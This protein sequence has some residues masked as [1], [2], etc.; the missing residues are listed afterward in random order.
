M[1]GS[2]FDISKSTE[3]NYED[4]NALFIGKYGK[5]RANLDYT[6][7]KKYSNERQLFQDTLLD[8]FIHTTIHDHN[9]DI[10]CEKPLH[11]WIIFTSG[12]MGSGKSHTLKW[13]ST[14][15]YFPLESFIR[16]D[17]DA[18][19]ELLPEN[20]L[21]I[22]TYPETAGYYTQKEVN[23]LSEILTQ[24]ALDAG[25]NILVEG[26]LRDTWYQQYIRGL[27]ENYPTLKFAIF[28]FECT[29]ETALNRAHSRGKI[30]GRNVPDSLI[31]KTM[32]EIPIA[33]DILKPHVD[34]VYIF[35]TEGN[36]PIIEFSSTPDNDT[37]F[38]TFSSIFEMQC[39]VN[40]MQDL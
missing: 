27:R 7:H 36:T 28:S 31:E 30:T 6:Y 9:N 29:L 26:T 25:K 39:D 12:V 20:E 24:Y 15:K 21:Y 40:L 37:S 11:N 10:I 3:E 16:D 5:F 34:V 23:Y 32:K 18:L 19:R 8:K 2:T 35:N 4:I 14:H 13:L 22:S 38:E 17:P 1:I 33:L